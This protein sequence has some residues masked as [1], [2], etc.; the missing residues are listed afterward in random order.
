ML[1]ENQP[2]HRQIMISCQHEIMSHLLIIIGFEKMIFFC[3]IPHVKRH[4]VTCEV[5]KHGFPHKHGFLDRSGRHRGIIKT[6]TL[7]E[8]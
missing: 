4:D 7:V 2:V 1:I 6:C 3:V 8:L 5:L